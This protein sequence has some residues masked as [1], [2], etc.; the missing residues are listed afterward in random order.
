MPAIL[1]VDW[2]ERVQR[3]HHGYPW[4]W[5]FQIQA[6]RTPVG[7]PTLFVTPH[8]ESVTF[9]SAEYDPMPMAS[10]PIEVSGEGDLPEHEITI[11]DNH[12]IIAPYLFSGLGFMGRP[13]TAFLVNLENPAA[14][15]RYDRRIAKWA[16]SAEGIVFRIGLPSWLKRQ[17][18]QD[19]ISARTCQAVFGRIETGCPYVVNAAAGFTDCDRTIGACTARGEDLKARNLPA[20]LPR[21]F[22]AYPG[23]PAA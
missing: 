19:V 6:D 8:P 17:I 4:V 9:G 21:M 7:T 14:F 1:P 23:V 5:L 10:T 22:G 18:P 20:V 3:A 12:R 13:C 16:M 11:V 2:K 15:D